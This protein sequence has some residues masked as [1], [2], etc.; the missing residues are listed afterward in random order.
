MTPAPASQPQSV[1]GER[2]LRIFGQ[3]V[4]VF[5]EVAAEAARRADQAHIDAGRLPH[6]SKPDDVPAR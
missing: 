1:I 3:Q 4:S 6:L 5:A 2:S